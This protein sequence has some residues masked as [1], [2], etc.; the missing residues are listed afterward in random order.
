MNTQFAQAIKVAGITMVVTSGAPENPSFKD[1]DGWT[2]VLK[3][4]RKRYTVPFYMGRGHGG[5]E[6][7]IADVLSCLLSDASGYDNAQSFLDWCA[8]FGLDDDSRK[9]LAT[10]RAC[11]RISRRLR[12]L[13]GDR[14]DELLEASADY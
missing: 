5:A 9:A 2:C 11:E 8:E 10:F 3:C 7:T 14:F 6:P 1:S 13:L 12:R 4:G